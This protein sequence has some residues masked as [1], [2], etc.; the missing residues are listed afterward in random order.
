MKKIY[1][2]SGLLLLLY[3][4]NGYSQ[5]IW[6]NPIGQYA[7]NPA[8]AAMNDIGEVVASYYNTYASANNSPQ[9]FLLM[10][11]TSFPSDKIGAGFRLTNETGGVLKNTM[12]EATFVYR[13]PVWRDSKLSFG[14][15]GVY[16]Q[17][18]IDQGKVNAKDPEDPILTEAGKAGYYFDAN[19]GVSLNEANKYYIGAACYNL[20][21]QQT[22]WL[23]PGFTNR[24]SRLVSLSGMYCLSLLNGDGKL[25]TTGVGMFY[26]P[27][28]KFSLTYDF[29]TRLIFKKSCWIGAGYTNNM[30]KILCGLY[31]QDLS[32]GYAGGIGV[33]DITSYTYAFPK[34][35]LFL[36]MELN[37]SKSSKT[38]A[39]R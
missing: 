4:V 5:R 23:L 39:S 24:A 7:Y 1:I 6:S 27:Q 28:D 37:T 10:G 26:E 34:H 21:G 32:I 12:A 9:G 19:F 13:T 17:L 11:S 16:N 20:L 8:G 36:R 14:L 2:I 35:E 15:S 3:T 30:A 29:S 33:G 22:S 25:E 18:G 38:N 31:I